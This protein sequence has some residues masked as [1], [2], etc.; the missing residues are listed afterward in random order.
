MFYDCTPGDG[1]EQKWGKLFVL[2]WLSWQILYQMTRSR[3][4]Y[5]Y[6]DEMPCLGDGSEQKW[7]ELLEPCRGVFPER[8]PGGA[9]ESRHCRVSHP[10]L[11]VFSYHNI[12]Y[13]IVVFYVLSHIIIHQPWKHQAES[14]PLHVECLR[15]CLFRPLEGRQIHWK[16]SPQ[17]FTRSLCIEK[18]LK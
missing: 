17:K 6:W 11:P 16:G 10:S 5:W 7:G 2:N 1:S 15:P 12:F 9:Q 13:L 18:R 4:R 14:G 3:Y 8:G